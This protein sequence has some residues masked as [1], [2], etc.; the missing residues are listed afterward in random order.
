MEPGGHGGGYSRGGP[1]PPPSGRKWIHAPPDRGYQGH[2]HWAPPP[3]R[4]HEEQYSHQPVEYRR[5]PAPSQWAPPPY[6][7]HHV[8]PRDG[9]ADHRWP[10]VNAG[11][12]APGPNGG[13]GGW[14][15]GSP[16]PSRFIFP[17]HSGDH[18]QPD[19]QRRN[20]HRRREPGRPAHQQVC[21]PDH[22]DKSKNEKEGYGEC[23]S[24]VIGLREDPPLSRSFK[25]G[26]KIPPVHERDFFLRASS[27]TEITIRVRA[28]IGRMK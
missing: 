2:N 22:D 14:G 25:I 17:G 18:R 1:P 8:H 3:L 12:P 19:H 11:W 24:R 27:R 13:S 5:G 21:P 20:P 23:H 16:R 15:D 4:P 28:V 7:G 9:D 10:S 6:A 26:A